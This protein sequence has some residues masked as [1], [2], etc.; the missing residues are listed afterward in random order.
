M[1]IYT[2]CYL[3]CFLSVKFPME[4]SSSF[5]YIYIF[6]Q[7][8]KNNDLNRLVMNG[9]STTL[10]WVLTCPEGKKSRLMNTQSRPFPFPLGVPFPPEQMIHEEGSYLLDKQLPWNPKK[11]SYILSLGSIP[12]HSK[13]YAQVHG[14]FNYCQV[15]HGQPRIPVSK[16]DLWRAHAILKWADESR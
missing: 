11:Q 7:D 16:K 9:I 14:E 4:H 5:A 10:Y 6:Q 1:W 12:S 2:V 15:N 13:S 8:S 3:S